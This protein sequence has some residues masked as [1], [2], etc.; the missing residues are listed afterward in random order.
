MAK[1]MNVLKF[2][3]PTDMFVL[4]FAVNDYQGQDHLM[5]LDHKTD[6]F[7]DGFHRLALCA[8]A[9]VH[10]LLADHPNAAVV[11]LEFQTAIWNRKTAQ[12][13]H[14]GVAQHYQVPVISYADALFP[15]YYRLIETL[16]PYNYSVPDSMDMDHIQPFPHGCAPCQLQHITSQFREKGCK[17]L[18]VFMQRSGIP[19]LDPCD[20][21]GRPC[22]LPFFAHDAVHPSALGHRIAK[23]LI[24]EAIASTALLSRQKRQR[25]WPPS[26]LLPQ[27]S[28]WLVPGPRYHEKLRA[29]T[30]FVLV[31]DTMEVFARKD[32][33]L[34]DNHTDGFVLKGDQLAERV[35]WIATNPNGGESIT[36]SI[37]IPAHNC[38]AVYISVL[39]SYENVGQFTVVVEDD[40]KMTRTNPKTVD[41]LWEPRISIP[42]DIQLTPDDPNSI[43]CTGKC[44][45]TVTTLP[46]HDRRGV[47]KVKIVSLSV[48]KCI[49]Y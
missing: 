24:V 31:L 26:H 37:D 45:I 36:F 18:C 1:R 33:L 34:S 19:H 20:V 14:M 40:L 7:F 11:F 30:D 21:R 29:I 23:D 22:Y 25:P 43:G 48:R 6:V 49:G 17:S 12:L 46:N 16:A 39:K 27:H 42:S 35:G 38:Y 44:K 47:N 8:E 13:L 5:H 32:P 3:H 4:E 2:P 9:V 28:G 15:E 10:K 41:C